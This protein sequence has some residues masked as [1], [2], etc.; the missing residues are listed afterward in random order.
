MQ[1][2][3]MMGPSVL[4]VPLQ[5]DERVV[6]FYKPSYT[7]DKVAYWFLFALTVWF[8]VGFIFMYMALT[9]E[10]KNP[11]GQVVTTH[12]VIQLPGDPTQQPT[13]V[14][15]QAIHDLEP[16]RQSAGGGG[17]G[18]LLGAAIRAGVTAV[19][20]SMAEKK[21]KAD[22]KYWARSTAVVL[23]DHGGLRTQVDSKDATNLGVLL[24][25][26]MMMGGFNN[27]PTVHHEP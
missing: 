4:G 25:N 19:A 8:V 23:I 24:A 13:Q 14:Y 26:G 6:Y 21:A 3:M 10:K 18:G 11:R 1:P 5:P 9:I 22:P 15:L 16:V 2:G 20:N 17:G 27:H 7:G 12:R